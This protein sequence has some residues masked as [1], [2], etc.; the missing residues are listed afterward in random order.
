MT[1]VPANTAQTLPDLLRAMPKAEA[2]VLC[3]LEA[4]TICARA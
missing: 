3:S 4:A 2:C 1:T